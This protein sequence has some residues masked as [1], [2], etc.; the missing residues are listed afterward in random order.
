MNDFTPSG[1]KQIDWVVKKWN[2]SRL[3][4]LMK[5]LFIKQTFSKEWLE[6]SFKDYPSIKS[7]RPMDW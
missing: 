7:S 3:F 2:Q 1:D 5:P 6:Q 4:N